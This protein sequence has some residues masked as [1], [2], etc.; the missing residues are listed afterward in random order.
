[1]AETTLELPEGEWEITTVSDDGVR[2]F[3]DGEKVLENWTHHGPTEDRAVVSLAA[4]KHR[5]RVE[6]FE[7]DGWA[8]LAFRIERKTP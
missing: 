1:M 2:V 8:W 5:I 3:V 4:G 7:I 6:H